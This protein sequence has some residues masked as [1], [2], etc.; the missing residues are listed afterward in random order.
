MRLAGQTQLGYYPTPDRV[1]DL[2]ATWLDLP[3]GVVALDPSCGGGDALAALAPHGRTYGIELD[4]HRAAL[5][6]ETLAAVVQAGF[7]ETLISPSSF[8]FLLLNPPYDHDAAT[9]IRTE[10]A[11]L[12]RALPLLAPG[13]VLVFIVPE[14]QMSPCWP[15]LQAHHLAVDGVWRFPEPEYDRFGQ[16]V[17]LGHRVPPREELAR[18][19]NVWAWRDPRS[20][21]PYSL[22]FA[23]LTPNS[24]GRRLAAPVGRPPQRFQLDPQRPAALAAYLTANPGAFGLLRARTGRAI[25]PSAEHPV[26]PPLP[27]HR[28]HLAT[29]LAA[30]VLSGALGTG[31]QRHLVRGHVVPVETV[32]VTE[33]DGEVTRTTRRSF[34]VTVTTLHPDGTLKTWGAPQPALVEDDSDSEDDT[35]TEQ[36]AV[37]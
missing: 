11:F 4:Q 10:A 14:N 31:E 8:G 35:A 24:T 16:A 27:L 9:G 5:A 7:E 25:A 32:E 33:E 6:Q 36:E 19:T 3:D 20:R 26:R 13:G 18:R 29:L 15:I 22:E 37:S 34:T 12:A 30:G 23:P 2:L 21:S 28:G 1:R 17:L